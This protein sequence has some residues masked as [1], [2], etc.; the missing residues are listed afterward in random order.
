MPK[1]YATIGTGF[2]TVVS[3]EIKYTPQKNEILMQS[4][5]PE[6]D[7]IARA[8]GTWVK[9]NAKKIEELDREFNQNKTTLVEHFSTA[10]IL[11]DT[12]LQEELKNELV[13]LQN[14]Y[15]KSYKEIMGD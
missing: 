7:Y 12:D 1:I 8:D 6:G 13:E 10:L 3:D 11:G 9:D 5:R 15:D 14:Q 2:M 4:E